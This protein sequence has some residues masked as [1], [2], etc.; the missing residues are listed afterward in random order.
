[1][2]KKVTCAATGLSSRLPVSRPE[3]KGPKRLTEFSALVLTVSVP[4]TRQPSAGSSTN[5]SRGPQRRSRGVRKVLSGQAAGAR[6]YRERFGEEAPG[7]TIRLGD[8]R[9]ALPRDPRQDV[10]WL[11]SGAAP[12]IVYASGAARPQRR[13]RPATPDAPDC[14]SHRRRVHRT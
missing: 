2:G 8:G 9:D 6:S 11:S 4:L 7:L 10:R 5:C 12:L 13:S 14:R 3:T 1:M